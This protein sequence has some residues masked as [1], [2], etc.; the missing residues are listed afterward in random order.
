MAMDS[1][2]PSEST[3]RL[4]DDRQHHHH[5]QGKLGMPTPANG[6]AITR[7]THITVTEDSRSTS[8]GDSSHDRH[9]YNQK[10]PWAAA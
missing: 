10:A 2:K 8:D 1:L 9:M 5:P 7:T 4:R 3:E 6:V